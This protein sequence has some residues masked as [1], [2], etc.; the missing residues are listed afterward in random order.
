MELA[1]ES[2]EIVGPGEVRIEVTNII[3]KFLDAPTNNRVS[4]DALEDLYVD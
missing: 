3:N 4:G 1:A 2:T